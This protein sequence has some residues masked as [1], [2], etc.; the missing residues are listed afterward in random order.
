ML[1]AGMPI[2]R[3]LQSVHKSGRFGRVFTQI[4][5]GVS[6][7]NSLTDIIQKHPAQF[8]KLDVTLIRTGEETGQLAEMLEELSRWYSFRQRIN[9]LLFS[10]MAYPI[11]MI[12]ALAVLAP[13]VPFALS[14][15][16]I[17]IYV[18]GLLTILGIFYIP[19][20]LILAIKMFSPKEGPLRRMLDMFVIQLPIVGK[21][22]RELELSR[23]ARVFAVTY[24]AGIPIIRCCEMAAGAVS[25][26][27]M[28]ARLEGAG[29]K[30]RL[31]QEMSLGFSSQLPLEFI[32]LWKTGEES[33]MLDDTAWRLSAMH[34][35]NAERR[36]ATIAQWTPRLVYVIVAC[37]MIYYI[38]KGYSQIYG[39][40]L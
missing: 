40:L 33:G 3:A 32:S 11:L 27:D 18:R 26:T 23:Y 22:V 36:F 14:G 15:F 17:A 1:N 38:F 35:E 20:A 7:G 34:A 24:R 4:E 30:A 39:N 9:R 8:K 25:N 19:A 31:G 16:D 6:R 28:L 10:G 2:T 21:A 5:Q 29:Q 13:V 37:V 12:H